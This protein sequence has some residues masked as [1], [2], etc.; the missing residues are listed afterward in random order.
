MLLEPDARLI[1]SIVSESGSLLIYEETK[2]IW[3]AQFTDVPVAI[4]RSNLDGLPG[5]IVTLGPTG[6]VTVGFL[7]TDPNLFQVPPLNLAELNYEK[8]Q[9]ELAELEKDIQAEV[10]F[11]DVSLS[12]SAAERELQLKLNVTEKL[13]KCLYETNIREPDID[14]RMC[15]ISLTMRSSSHLEQIQIYFQTEPPLKC[16]KPLY[17][18]AE[19]KYECWERLD[20]WVYLNDALPLPSAEVTAIV[21]FI[22]KQSI[23]RILEKRIRLPMSMFYA[24]CQPHKDGAHKVTLTL[25]QAA[26]LTLAAIFSNEFTIDDGAQAIGLKYIYSTSVV[27]IVEGKNSNRF[28]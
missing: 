21:S 9:K 27:T 4:Q 28:R 18:F 14:Y 16:S 26:G 20:T 17:V 11:T 12:N 2:L 1:S 19:P 15:L 24:Q 8:A 6:I 13:E 25:E 5:A 22:N 3:A 23:C 7:G 10:D